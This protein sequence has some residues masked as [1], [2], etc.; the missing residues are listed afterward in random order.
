MIRRIHHEAVCLLS[1][2]HEAKHHVSVILDEGQSLNK[3][4]VDIRYG[5]KSIPG[6]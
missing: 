6:M 3:S 1:K 5:T 2:L 4:F